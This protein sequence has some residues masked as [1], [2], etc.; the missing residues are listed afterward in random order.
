MAVNSSRTEQVLSFLHQK[1]NLPD[2]VETLQK[3]YRAAK[4]F[5]HLVFDNFFPS[6]VLDSILEELPPFDSEKWIHEKYEQMVKSNLR[7]ACD[8]GEHGFQFASEIHSAAFLYLISELTGVRALLPDPYL[9]A[10]GYHAVPE[11][12]KFDIHADRNADHFTGLRRSCVMLTYLNKNWS[13]ELGGQLEL[14][15]EDATQCE[16]VIEPL[17]NRVVI[18][19]VGD[20]NYHAVRPVAANSGALRRSFICYYHVVENNFVAHNSLWAPAVYREF[21]SPWRKTIRGLI[22]PLLLKA[23][24]RKKSMM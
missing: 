17:F 18:F 7:S 5:P 3:T 4:P 21:E 23:L 9:T 14:Y 16:H 24:R 2:T 1:V 13:P 22:P 6:E 19:E 15:N 11:G 12:G 8:L 20:H 10:S